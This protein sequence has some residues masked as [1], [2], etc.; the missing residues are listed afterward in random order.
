MLS[1]RIDSVSIQ[2]QDILKLK[3]SANSHGSVTSLR[4]YFV[5]LNWIKWA[6]D[7]FSVDVNSVKPSSNVELFMRQ[8]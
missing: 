3:R 8:T 5:H 4:E 2:F 7:S 1:V 6:V